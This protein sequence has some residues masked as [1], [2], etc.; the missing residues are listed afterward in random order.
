MRFCNCT[1]IIKFTANH[2]WRC[3]QFSKGAWWFQK[4]PKVIW[5]ITSTTWGE[6]VASLRRLYTVQHQQLCKFTMCVTVR[7]GLTKKCN[8]KDTSSAHSIHLPDQ[9]NKTALATAPRLSGNTLKNHKTAGGECR[10]RHGEAKLCDLVSQHHLK[11]AITKLAGVFY[12]FTLYSDFDLFM[13]N[14]HVSMVT[15]IF[16][17]KKNLSLLFLL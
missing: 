6:N 16:V 10:L 2:W 9:N 17:G 14:C 11:I 1:L 15:L 12:Y 13:C 5:Y 3:R 4:L 7:S 8:C